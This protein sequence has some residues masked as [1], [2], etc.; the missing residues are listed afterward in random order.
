MLWV[1]NMPIK[2]NTKSKTET[3]HDPAVPIDL[4]YLLIFFFFEGG[5]GSHSLAD[6]VSKVQPDLFSLA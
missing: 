2:R 4:S 1:E 3:V 6:L 5:G